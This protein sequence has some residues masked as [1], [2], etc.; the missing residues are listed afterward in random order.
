MCWRGSGA[1]AYTPESMAFMDKIIE[2]SGLGEGHSGFLPDGARCLCTHAHS[3]TRHAW[4]EL[5]ESEYKL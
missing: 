5:T 1:Q 2:K 3:R 4:Q